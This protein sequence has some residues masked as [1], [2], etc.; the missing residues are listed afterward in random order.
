VALPGS[1]ASSRLVLALS[2]ATFLQWLGTSAVLP[3]LPLYLAGQGASDFVIGLAMAAFFAAGVALQYPVGRLGDTVGPMRVLVTALA[4]ITVASLGYLLPVGPW[5]EVGLRF[6]QG[7]GAGAAEVTCLSLVGKY[8]PAARRGSA[9]GSIFG[10]QLAALA[11]APLFGSIVGVRYMTWLFLAGAVT[12]LVA[13]GPVIIAA[14]ETRA[15]D[16]IADEPGPALPRVRLWT[17]AALRGAFVVALIA[18]LTTGIYESCWTL[19]LESRGASSWQIGLSW[20]LFCVPFVAM[21]VPAGRLADRYD[22]RWL[23]CYS[24]LGS[25][26]LLFVYPFIDSV[27]VIIAL[28]ATEGFGV[29]LAYPAAQSLLAQLAPVQQLGQTQGVFSTLQTAA[30]AA[31]AAA[32]GAL[33]GPAAWLPFVVVG[34]LAAALLLAVPRIWAGV[35]GRVADG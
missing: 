15:A 23:V 9:Y 27:A 17:S 19:L 22:R 35:A 7:A 24:L 8:V 30:I 12:A 10:A 3:I 21:S 13:C 32:G 33:F 14:R 29:A 20:C 4:T 26:I 34:A 2:V 28:G 25:V 18:G 11:I 16:A 1:A 5:A 31:S 6:L